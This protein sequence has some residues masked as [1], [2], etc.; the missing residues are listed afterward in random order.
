MLFMIVNIVVNSV[1]Y[2]VIEQIDMID[3]IE[4]L[5]DGELLIAAVCLF[6]IDCG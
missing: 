5:W 6:A 2:V 4:W 1:V 3:G